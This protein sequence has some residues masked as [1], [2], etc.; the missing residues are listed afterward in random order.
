MAVCLAVQETWISPLLGKLR[1]HI[2]QSNWAHAVATTQALGL[3]N[4][5]ATAN[6]SLCHSKRSHLMQCIFPVPGLG[7]N[8]AK[9]KK[10]ANLRT[11]MVSLLLY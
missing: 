1:F 8:V 5:P 7:P 6:V 3:W 4:P 10:K 9:K 11:G 2:V